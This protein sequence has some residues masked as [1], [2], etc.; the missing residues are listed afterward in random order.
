MAQFTIQVLKL[1]KRIATHLGK[2][3]VLVFMSS[4]VCL[5]DALNRE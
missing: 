5:G 2:N 4:L 1:W 3:W